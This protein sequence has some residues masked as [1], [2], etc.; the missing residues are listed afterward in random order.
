M[1]HYEVL[2]ILKPTLTEEEVKIPAF[3]SRKSVSETCGG[4]AE[5][6]NE[7]GRTPRKVKRKFP[8]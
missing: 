3:P 5:K 4:S 8:A 2:F 6:Q 7:N 1:K